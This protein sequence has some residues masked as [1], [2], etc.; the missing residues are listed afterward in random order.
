MDS[1]NSA[2]GLARADSTTRLFQITAKGGPF[3]TINL[4]DKAGAML[5]VDI[6]LR[7]DVSKLR[8]PIEQ[9]R[10]VLLDLLAERIQL[11][12]ENHRRQAIGGSMP[13]S[14]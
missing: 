12:A 8:G 2:A 14:G 1:E 6:T 4:E 5:S 7:M 10:W 13:K 3:L 11:L 9:E